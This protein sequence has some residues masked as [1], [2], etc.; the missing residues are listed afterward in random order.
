MT[1]AMRLAL[2]TAFRE[3]SVALEA[4]DGRLLRPS[5]DLVARRGSDLHP[6]IAELL[7]TAN[8]KPGDLRE[9]WIDVGPGSYTGLRI[10]LALARTWRRVAGCTLRCV[11][12]CD[13]LALL[14]LREHSDLAAAERFVVT[15]DARRASWF[16]AAYAVGEAG[17]AR[18]E[19]P[20]CVLA[21]DLAEEVGDSALVTLE[22]QAA[23]TQH[24][25]L[26]V[27]EPDAAQL[28]ELEALAFEEDEP[29]PRYLMPPL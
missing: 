16:V 22:G 9:I 23:P 8:A 5:S 19:A 20:R 24:H 18:L 29:S 15:L 11:F 27:E 13:Q 12:S 17:L 6:A 4:A 2:D 21:T 28:F 7:A 14:A 1:R 25:S 3:I 26:S 10:G